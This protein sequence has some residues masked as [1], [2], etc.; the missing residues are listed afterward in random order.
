MFSLMLFDVTNQSQLGPDARNCK[1]CGTPL[2]RFVPDAI[3]PH[4]LLE[5][6]LSE[7]GTGPRAGTS[8]G[9]PKSP[10]DHGLGRD[11]ELLE[12]IAR[13]GMGIVYRAR[14]VSLNRTVALKMILTGQFAS[15][16]EVKRFHAEAGAASQLDHPNIVP[17]YEVGELNGTSFFQHEVHRGRDTRRP[18]GRSKVSPLLSI[19]S[20]LAGQSL[21]RRSLRPSARDSAP[22]LGAILYE[23]SRSRIS[24]TPVVPILD[25]YPD[26]RAYTHASAEFS[27]V[28]GFGNPR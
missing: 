3:C 26:P 18:N 8:V 5:A 19:R 7:P 17:I 23:S 1:K 25:I 16:M 14:Q 20:G 27:C 6:G 22:S 11:Y 24:V 2:G 9:S 13:G 4:C 15:E 21:P 12:E 28:F 10:R